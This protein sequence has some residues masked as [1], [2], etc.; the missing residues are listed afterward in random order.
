MSSPLPLPLLPSCTH[1]M[2]I[3]G[4]VI[5]AAL[6]GA[7]DVLEG[8]GVVEA[9]LLREV[10]VCVVEAVVHCDEHLAL[11]GI[12]HRVVLG[13]EGERRVGGEEGRRERERERERKKRRRGETPLSTL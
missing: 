4:G 7:D 10:E 3:K 8:E 1:H 9:L 5:P 2:D 11:T 12:H 13:R 6:W